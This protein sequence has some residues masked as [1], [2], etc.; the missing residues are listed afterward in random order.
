MRLVTLR[1]R[2]AARVR[3]CCLPP[4]GTGPAFYAGW[5]ASLPPDVEPVSVQLP[6]RGPLA[7]LPSVTAPMELV[8]RLAELLGGEEENDGRPLALFGH[9]LGAL[10]AYETAR[11]LRR[12]R[13]RPPVLLAVSAFPAP[14][15]DTYTSVFSDRLLAGP[16]G[17][18]DLLGQVPPSPAAV[19][20]FLA[21]ALLALQYRHH[22]E[23]PLD[24]P[25]ALYGGASD[26]LAPGPRLAAWNDLVTA[27]VEPVLFPGGHM[28]LR[29][30]PGGLLRR[31]GDEVLAAA[32]YAAAP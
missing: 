15:L 23:P 16:E 28:Y 5:P 26:P 31:L 6:G 20:P 22:D 24:V 17:L 8:R 18:A 12:T 27:P 25:L 7:D 21:D 3:L 19:V 14:H 30:A 10:L 1:S 29:Q 13:R 2:P 9:S 32:R 4:A 11:A